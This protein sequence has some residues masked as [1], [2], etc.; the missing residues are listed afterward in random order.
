MATTVHIDIIF[1]FTGP[2]KGW[3]LLHVSSNPEKGY[4]LIVSYSLF[5]SVQTLSPRFQYFWVT[6]M[7]S[8][9][10]VILPNLTPLTPTLNM[11]AWNVRHS[12]QIRQYHNPEDHNL[13]THCHENMAV[14]IIQAKIVRV[15]RNSYF[16]PCMVSCC[17]PFSVSNA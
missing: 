7:C 1:P 8:P 11:E 16:V 14:S 5:L 12:I 15:Q 10:N 17:G 4:C 6:T 3:L 9:A 13:I 2:N